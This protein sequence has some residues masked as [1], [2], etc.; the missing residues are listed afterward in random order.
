[1]STE[2]TSTFPA[3]N[4][5]RVSIPA[6]NLLFTN[7]VEQELDA[8]VDSMKPASVFVLVDSNTASFVLPRLQAQSKAIAAAKIIQ[9]PA[10]EK[11][12]N[13]DTLS[14]IWK[15]LGDSDATR[16]SLL[17]NVGGGVITDIGAFAAATFKRGIPFINIPTTL[18]G[19]VDASVGGK[20]G[21]NFNS[22]KN[23]IGVIR[24]ADLVIISTTF[25]RTL[26]SQELLS[27]YAEM[28]KHGFITS[29]EMTNRLLAYDITRYEPE[30]LLNLLR[31]SVNVKRK[32]V[33]QDLNDHG[34][35]KALNLG[36]TAA[37]AFESLALQRGSMISHGY[38]VAFGLVVSL[39]LSRMKFDFPS[40]DLQRYA[41]YVADNYGAFSISCDDY[42]T[43]LGFMH[44]DKKNTTTDS[45]SCS[46]LSDYGHVELDTT[47]TDLEM[48]AALD[49]YRD[50][51]HIP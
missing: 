26:T 16:K 45:L 5:T 36:H 6:P 33:E 23:E 49:I 21:I 4:E 9:T 2:N 46:I 18:L 14:N 17:I 1:M 42:P 35:R 51:L 31:E 15:Q 24:Q 7:H 39:V 27:G 32:I 25:F 3:G 47:V 8:I 48:T 44:H 11:H 41:K 29:K 28:I 40:D 37:H 38:A 43:L 34:V 10:G 50:L 13:L 12:K 22:L 20:T 30:Q 19:A